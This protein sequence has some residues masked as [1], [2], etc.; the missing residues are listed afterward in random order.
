MKEAKKGVLTSGIIIVTL[1]LIIPVIAQ[2]L[3]LY[4][5][6]AQRLFPNVPFKD[7]QRV[8]QK[9][10]YYVV[11]D[12]GNHR[13]VFL[14][15]AMQVER[16]IG[17]IGQAIGEFYYPNDL[18]VD[19]SGYIYVRD[20]MNRRYQIFDW[21]G[22]PIGQFPNYPEAHGLAVNSKGEVLLGQPQRGKLVSVYNRAGKLVRSFGELRKLSDFYGPGVADLDVQYKYA[23]NRIKLCVDKHDN[24]Y[25]GFMGAPVFQKYDA[26]GR[27]LFEKKMSGPQ[28]AKIITGFQKQRKSPVRRGIDD[29]PTPLIITGLAVDDATG[30]IYI[31]F[32]WDRAWIYVANK[33]GEGIAILEPPLREMLFQNIELSE[34]G[35][36]LL[37]ARLSVVKTDEAYKLKLPPAIRRR[38]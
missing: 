2:G 1:L 5:L 17:K 36:A 27:L 37:A 7:V 10:G 22:K 11:L 8:I 6:E 31:S 38:K 25:V 16:Q 4:T 28:V 15:S 24:V 29:V 32:Q 20:S 26:T 13:V 21:S 19:A 35:T 33:E 12:A 30:N 23:I 34:D 3:K 9:R 14:N 18:A